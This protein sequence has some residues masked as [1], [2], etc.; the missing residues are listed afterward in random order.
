MVDE[1]IAAIETSKGVTQ[2]LTAHNESGLNLHNYDQM[3]QPGATIY[4]IKCQRD[5]QHC[6]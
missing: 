5:A 1:K 3:Y 6:Y 4:E 2:D